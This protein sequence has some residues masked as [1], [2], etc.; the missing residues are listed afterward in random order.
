MITAGILEKTIERAISTLKVD[1]ELAYLSLTSKIE[2]PLRDKIA[3][4]FY[5]KFKGNILVCREWKSSK[6]K[7]N[8]KRIDL[9]LINKKNKKVKTLV[10]F[11]AYYLFDYSRVSK[12]L[13]FIK[14]LKKDQNRMKKFADANTEC[15]MVLLL[16]D[17]QTAIPGKLEPCVKYF[18]GIKSHIKKKLK[19]RIMIL[20]KSLP[21][22][23]WG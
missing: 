11:K 18:K 19:V 12:K 4:I 10:E 5:R 1:D 23:I 14:Y 16:T 20:R 3:F 9:A 7:K 21:M 15:L 22:W 13:P 17:P 6:P 8:Q 2:Q